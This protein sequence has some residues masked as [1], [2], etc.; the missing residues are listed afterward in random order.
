MLFYK[1]EVIIVKSSMMF[2]IFRLSSIPCYVNVPSDLFVTLVPMCVMGRASVF[3]VRQLNVACN[4]DFSFS[5]F[6][7]KP[8]TVREWNIQV[9]VMLK[10]SLVCL[11]FLRKW[12][13]NRS[14]CVGRITARR[15]QWLSHRSFLCHYRRSDSVACRPNFYFVLS[16]DLILCC[17]IVH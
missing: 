10:N 14:F 11:F 4:P 2:R 8:T 7:A 12:D 1:I 15:T 6:L 17:C 3:Q 16:F 5:N 9:C 13:K